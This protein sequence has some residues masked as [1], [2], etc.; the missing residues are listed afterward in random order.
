MK[1][2]RE[3]LETSLL[4]RDENHADEAAHTEA[5]IRAWAKA[6]GEQV[7]EVCAVRVDWVM[8]PATTVE[9]STAT[10]P[11]ADALRAMKLPEP[12]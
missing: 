8:K 1:T 12:E 6:Y 3:I 4:H 11:L 5:A 9:G 7:R 10:G 2:L